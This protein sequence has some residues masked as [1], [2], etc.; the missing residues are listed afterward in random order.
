MLCGLQLCQ[1]TVSTAATRNS[2][3]CCSTQ[4]TAPPSGVM[5][6][7]LLYLTP[8]VHCKWFACLCMTHAADEM[9]LDMCSYVCRY[10]FRVVYIRFLFDYVCISGNI[11]AV[12]SAASQESICCSCVHFV[13]VTN[14]MD[15]QRDIQTVCE[16]TT[17]NNIS[18]MCTHLS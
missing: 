4:K 6:V 3:F 9:T 14:E 1:W 7:L 11:C 15:G 17:A 5:F 12:C 10:I 13:V 16:T 2:K 18:K 8:C